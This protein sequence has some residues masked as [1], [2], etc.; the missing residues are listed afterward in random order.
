MNHEFLEKDYTVCILF[1]AFKNI[2]L[3]LLF[4]IYVSMY[5]CTAHTCG[6]PLRPEEGIGSLRAGAAVPVGSGT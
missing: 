6:C 1:P 2:L 4:L 3:L 5:I